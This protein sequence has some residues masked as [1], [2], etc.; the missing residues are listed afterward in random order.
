MNFERSDYNGVIKDTYKYKMPYRYE[1]GMEEVPSAPHV[2]KEGRG[3][4]KRDVK[5]EKKKK[6]SDDDDRKGAGKK[7]PFKDKRILAKEMGTK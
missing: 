2:D 3:I 6:Q 7:D 4:F 1:E 5:K